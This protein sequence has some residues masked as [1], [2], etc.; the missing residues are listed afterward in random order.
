MAFA[1][2]LIASRRGT[3]ALAVIAALIAGL[4]VLVYVKRYRDSLQSTAAPVTV[5][6]AKQPIP[7]GTPG[8]LVASQGL[9][10]VTTIRESQL[11]D[12]AFSDPA[13]LTG[14]AA[15]HDIYPG[16][17]LT[18][19]DFSA[20]A[21]TAATKLTARQRVVSVPLDAAHGLST[22]LSIGDKVD[23]YGG[24]NVVP[25]GADGQPIAN[26][27]SRPVLRLLMQNVLVTDIKR[28]GSGV[29]GGS[30]STVSLRVDDIQA[31]KVAFAS[32]NGK[33][34]LA[35]RPAAGAKAS[36]P[37]LVTLETLLLGVKPAVME[38]ALGGQQ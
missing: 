27:Q 9:F 23:V 20:S 22:E 15:A 8:R 10:T 12:G 34:W 6:V 32:D 14:T 21:T 18:S 31:A 29:G 26:G 25:I 19:A 33:V 4:L 37:D 11:R 38:R 13:S 35:L 17:Q 30:G 2:R 1:Q 28:Q 24:F 36:R 7:A 5:L 3:L 16:Q